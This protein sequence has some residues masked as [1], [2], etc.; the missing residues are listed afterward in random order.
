MENVLNSARTE[1]GWECDY[2]REAECARRFSRLLLKDNDGFVVPKIY[3]E[4]TTK[5]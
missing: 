3:P 1:L 5:R 2:E 4:I